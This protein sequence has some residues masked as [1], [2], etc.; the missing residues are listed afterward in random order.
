M[1]FQVSVSLAGDRVMERNKYNRFK[2]I[3]MPRH[4]ICSTILT[5]TA[6]RRQIHYYE[7][8]GKDNGLD[9]KEDTGR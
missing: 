5:A 4:I 1:L 3:R 2:N 6:G 7:G 9:S 8:A